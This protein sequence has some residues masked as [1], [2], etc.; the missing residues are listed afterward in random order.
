MP[1]SN[2]GP[3]L[4]PRSGSLPV[5]VTFATSP[6]SPSPSLV[7]GGPF[8]LKSCWSARRTRQV[9]RCPGRLKANSETIGRQLEPCNGRLV[10]WRQPLQIPKRL[11]VLREGLCEI[12]KKNLPGVSSTERRGDLWS[13]SGPKHARGRPELPIGVFLIARWSCGLVEMARCRVWRNAVPA[14]F[15]LT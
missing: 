12:Y 4:Y 8:A 7:A 11:I 10:S 6:P 1:C 9:W 5:R 15:E 3:A 14:E 2:G 13:W